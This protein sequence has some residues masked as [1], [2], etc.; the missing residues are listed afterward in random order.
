MI[1]ETWIL[2]PV[3]LYAVGAFAGFVYAAY[4]NYKGKPL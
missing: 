1:R 2:L 3:I 4:A